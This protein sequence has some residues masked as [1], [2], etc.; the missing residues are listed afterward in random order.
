MVLMILSL[1]FSVSDSPLLPP[2]FCP[3]IHSLS[4]VTHSPGLS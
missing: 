4:D 3:V 1:S 2:L